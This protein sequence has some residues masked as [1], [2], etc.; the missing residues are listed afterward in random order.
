VPDVPTKT[1]NARTVTLD[2][3]TVQ[4]IV[5]R[6]TRSRS[7]TTCSRPSPKKPVFPLGPWCAPT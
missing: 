4:D 1:A 5:P 2:D 6:S 3:E 7:A